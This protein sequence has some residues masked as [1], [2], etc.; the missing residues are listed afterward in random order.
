MRRNRGRWEVR[1]RKIISHICNWK[2]IIIIVC[3]LYFFPSCC[4]CF[5]RNTRVENDKW[6]VLNHSIKHSNAPV[7]LPCFARDKLQ[8]SQYRSFGS[9]YL[10][11][12]STISILDA[13]ADFRPIYLRYT[14]ENH[15]SL[16]LFD[17]WWL[18][19]MEVNITHRFALAARAL[20]NFNYVFYVVDQT[21]IRRYAKS[22]FFSEEWI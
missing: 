5:A 10:A 21:S 2:S 1:Q 12:F 6:T 4:F 18:I 22:I 17:V 11:M 13:I 15:W 19:V 3:L 20:A 9:R 8:I 7:L 14:D 16:D